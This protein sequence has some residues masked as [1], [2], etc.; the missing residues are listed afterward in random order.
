MHSYWHNF[1][2][3]KRSPLY[4]AMYTRGIANGARKKI[5]GFDYHFKL[6]F[7]NGEIPGREWEFQKKRRMVLKRLKED[8]FFILKAMKL[9]YRFYEN[10]CLKLWNKIADLKIKKLSNNKLAKQFGKYA[11]SLSEFWSFGMIPLFVEED[12]TREIEKIC[13][14][15]LPDGEA[16]QAL[17]VFLTPKKEGVVGKEYHSLLRVAAIKNDKQRRAAILRHCENFGWMANQLY[18]HTFYPFSYYE[19][20]LKK[21]FKQNHRILLINYERTLAARLSDFKFWLEKINPSPRE[22]IIIESLNEAIY[23]R[24]WRQE[25]AYESGIVVVNFFEEIAKRLKISME[26]FVYCLPDEIIASLRMEKKMD[27]DKIF[28][29]KKG[30][31]YLPTKNGR[32]ITGRQ[33]KSWEY[34]LKNIM[35]GG[36]TE[37]YGTTAYPGNVRGQVKVVRT[38]ED[39]KNIRKGN[40]LVAPSTTPL[41]VPVL[42]K[43]SAIVTEEG[44]VLSHAS[45]ISRELRIPCVIGAKIATQV[46]K[47]GDLVEVDANNGVVRKIK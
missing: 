45:V 41:Y 24:S 23:Y 38:A 5:L 16:G 26:D 22:K 33:V 14:R 19:K 42:N 36:C 4:V 10:Y 9:H 30:F 40:I 29:R 47:D 25:K 12:L 17:Q 34:K 21:L 43:V 11:Y 20:R 27:R 37:I 1:A 39:L 35:V 7:F 18:T 32:I 2:P 6:Y 8:N 44:G 28:A 3:R 13:Q 15:K 46:L 31:V